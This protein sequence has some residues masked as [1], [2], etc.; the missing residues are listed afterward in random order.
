MLPRPEA[1]ERVF[2]RGDR[3]RAEC[4]QAVEERGASA[5]GCRLSAVGCRASGVGGG[6]SGVGR[7][8][9]VAPSGLELNLLGP[10]RRRGDD[11]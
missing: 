7:R 8:P 3:G 5:V 9:G 10:A 4:Q 11:A 1:Q 2:V 6:G